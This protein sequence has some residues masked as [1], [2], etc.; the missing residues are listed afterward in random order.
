MSDL[1]VDREEIAMEDDSP[2]LAGYEPHGDRPL[3]S[4]RMLRVMRVVVIVGVIGLI[5]PG[6]L[7][8]AS[9]AANIAERAC[10]FYVA[11]NVPN[12]TPRARFEFTG[13]EGPGWNCYADRFGGREL[14][15]R[16]MGLIPVAPPVD[17]RPEVPAENA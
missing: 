7:I 10:A 9:T 6:I 11:E 16:G 13:P 15:V 3:R 14:Y 4:Q 8:T 12:G 17:R 5:L 1:D 2:E